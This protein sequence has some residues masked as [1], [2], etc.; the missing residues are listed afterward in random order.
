MAYSHEAQHALAAM[1]ANQMIAENLE[2][3]G[4]GEAKKAFEYFRA[5]RDRT[6]LLDML[7]LR[8]NAKQ[9]F[10]QN[11][12]TPDH[13]GKVLKILEDTVAD[14]FDLTEDELI[15]IFG[16]AVR[17][18]TFRDKTGSEKLSTTPPARPVRPA[19]ARTSG[20][21]L[22]QAGEIFRGVIAE[23]LDGG[24]K[25]QHPDHPIERVLGII[26]AEH[27]G[28]S[29]FK[30][31]NTRWVEILS[32]RTLKSGRVVLELRPAQKPGG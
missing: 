26:D 1:L 31:K 16:W 30:V 20:S 28:G 9:P 17:L 11:K 25:I 13:C 12:N 32:T 6:Q 24:V 5:F 2:S 23:V 15:A 19:P 3:G 21:A 10:A 4:I 29:Q 22:L 7:R 18:A 8:S 27:M 14:Y